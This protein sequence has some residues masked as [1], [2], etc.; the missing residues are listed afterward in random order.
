MAR[1]TENSNFLIQEIG[2][3]VIL[4]HEGTEEEIANFDPADADN[5]AKAQKIIYDNTELTDEE[6]CFAHFWSGYFWAHSL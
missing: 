2:G 6:K 5:T 4:F 1:L 3:R